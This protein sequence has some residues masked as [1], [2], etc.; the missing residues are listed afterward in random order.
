[1]IVMRI[2]SIYRHPYMRIMMVMMVMIVMIL[3]DSDNK[4]KNSYARIV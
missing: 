4:R 1:M 3:D 2:I